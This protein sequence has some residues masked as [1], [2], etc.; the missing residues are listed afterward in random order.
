MKIIITEGQYDSLLKQV[1][2]TIKSVTDPYK[3]LGI[4][5]PSQQT[6]KKK[7]KEPE[8]ISGTQL[9][10]GSTMYAT[11]KYWAHIREFEGN[12]KNRVGGVKQPM[13]V[14]YYD[15][16]KKPTI[17]YGHT[18]G[19]T[20]GMKITKQQA[21]DFLVKDTQEASGCLRRILGN[22]K[23]NGLSTY[24]LTQGQFDAM[25]SMTYNAGCGNMR[26]SLFLQE[27]KKG[28]TKKAAELIK[29]FYTNN[30]YPGLVRRRQEEYKMFI[31]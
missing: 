8:K 28:N 27:L 2:Q 25:T 17:G 20:I 19:V 22:W 13:L 1:N 9:M 7:V 18:E 15:S 3:M 16:V 10:D 21:D 23:K 5:R 4:T 30:N 11:N 24:K 29:T 26:K 14:G 12:P 6:T 31:S